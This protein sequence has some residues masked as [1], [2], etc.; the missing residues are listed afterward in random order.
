MRLLEEVEDK[1]QTWPDIWWYSPQK[2]ARSTE[3]PF[4]R[5]HRFEI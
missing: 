3:G 2:I 5:V 4:S 1:E